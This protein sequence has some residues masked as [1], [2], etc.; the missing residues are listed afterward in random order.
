MGRRERIA[1]LVRGLNWA[2]K[3]FE[4]KLPEMDEETRVV[5]SRMRDSHLR[6]IIACEEIV[7]S[8]AR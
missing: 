3:R 6:S 5:F 2:V 7:Q 4:E 8:L 1:F